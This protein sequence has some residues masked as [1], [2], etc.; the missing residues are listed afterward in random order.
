MLQVGWLVGGSFVRVL[1]NT[2]LKSM[3]RLQ[4]ENVST[5]VRLRSRSVAHEAKI[6]MRKRKHKNKV[7]RS[8][9]CFMD[10]WLGC[11]LCNKNSAN[12]VTRISFLLF[13]QNNL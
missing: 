13:E 1:A 9:N 10:E 11:Y 8:L 7:F 4:I 5:Q 12:C 3:P 2:K 6:T